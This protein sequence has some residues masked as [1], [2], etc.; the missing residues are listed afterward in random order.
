MLEIQ[1]VYA[2]PGSI[3]RESHRVIFESYWKI[4]V[5]SWYFLVLK[6]KNMEVELLFG[7]QFV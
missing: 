2:E 6:Y 7:K 5:S 3:Y 4:Q 1:A